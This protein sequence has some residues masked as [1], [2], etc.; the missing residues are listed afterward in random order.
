[1]SIQFFSQNILFLLKKK[2]IYKKIILSVIQKE[3]K[4]V[5]NIDFIFCNDKFLSSLNK[6]YLKHNTF[7]DIITF[8]Y[9]S[10]FIAHLHKKKNKEKISSDI[11]ISIPQV[12]E[13]SKKFKVTFENELNRVMIHGILHLCGYKDKIPGKKKEMKKREN[14]YLKKI[15]S[16]FCTG[17]GT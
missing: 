9:T 1:M 5:G 8:D 4:K 13:N 14:Y 17:G 7:T 6:K 2:N 12:K 10:P 15:N 3:K 11:F 16:F